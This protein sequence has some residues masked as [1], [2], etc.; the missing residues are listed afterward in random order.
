MGQLVLVRADGADFYVEVA[1]VR[2]VAFDSDTAMSLDG[3][4]ETITALG[5]ELAKAWAAVRPSEASVELGLNLV[6]E[7]GKLIG[8][9]VEGSAESSLVVRLTWK[10][11]GA[12]S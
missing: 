5:K 7:N 12:S 6:V 8:L 4:R 9:L 11:D 2:P 3:V 10:S 1:D